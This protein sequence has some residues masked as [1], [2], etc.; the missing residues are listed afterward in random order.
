MNFHFTDFIPIDSRNLMGVDCEEF[1]SII[2]VL[3]VKFY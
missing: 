2:I 1:Q 3:K